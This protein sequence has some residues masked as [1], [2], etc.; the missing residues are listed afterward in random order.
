MS[1]KLSKQ[2]VANRSLERMRLVRKS[3][4]KWSTVPT[5]DPD[6]PG[7]LLR[8]DSCGLSRRREFVSDTKWQAISQ[9]LN[10]SATA[11]PLVF[12]AVIGR[13]V[14]RA[15]AYK[16][17]RG[18]SLLT[19]EL[20]NGSTTLVKPFAP[21]FHC[22]A[23]IFSASRLFC[24]GQSPL[25]AASPLYTPSQRVKSDRQLAYR[26]SSYLDTSR[27]WNDTSAG[28]FLGSDSTEPAN[29]MASILATNLLAPP[30]IRTLSMDLWDNVKIPYYKHLPGS[31][32]AAG[33]GAVSNQTLEYSSLIGIPVMAL[34]RAGNA[35]FT[36]KST[37]FDLALEPFSRTD[38]SLFVLQGS[39]IRVGYD[40]DSSTNL[41]AMAESF[42]VWISVNAGEP[43]Y[44]TLDQIHLESVINCSVSSL[45]HAC[46]VTAMRKIP[47][48]PIA[49]NLSQWEPNL[50]AAILNHFNYTIASSENGFSLAEA[51]IRSPESL[52]IPGIWILQ[53]APRAL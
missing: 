22:A 48:S 1:T 11:F 13:L 3:V 35:S 29:A 26:F 24:S 10:I 30:T 9:G 37:Y 47:S 27:S 2:T 17:E 18:G 52:G 33:W 53:I 39:G 15:T 23:F 19:L 14:K 25:S 43:L 38:E 40:V 45:Q 44:F 46:R 12:S 41:Q 6:C 36:L 16:L 49:F 21:I 42:R 20:L 51:Y 4:Q 8:L 28:S 32:D 5:D 34:T 31:P 7:S 50:M